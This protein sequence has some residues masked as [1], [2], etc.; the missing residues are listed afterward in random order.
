[1]IHISKVNEIVKGTI[2]GDNDLYVKGPCNI[3][4]GKKDYLSYIK[5]ENYLKY[6][7]N[8]LASVI[9]IDEKVNIPRENNQKTFLKVDNAAL[10]FI[11]FLNFY[12]NTN[13]VNA[14]NHSI[15]KSA[16]IHDF[17]EKFRSGA[18]N[19]PWASKNLPRSLGLQRVLSGGRVWGPKT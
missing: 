6:L 16:K 18:E 9:I 14:I 4:V 15:C 5:N 7:Q 12:D 19:R 3:Q 17:Y 13:N 11:K 8:T 1:M 2:Y 10:A